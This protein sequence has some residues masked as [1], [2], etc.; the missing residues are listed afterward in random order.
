M[1]QD[2]GITDESKVS[3]DTDDKP[4]NYDSEM[5]SEPSAKSGSEGEPG[6]ADAEP[7]KAEKDNSTLYFLIAAAIIIILTIVFFS[8]RFFAAEK[9]YPKVTYNGFVFE[10]YAGLWNTQWQQD[11]QLYNLRL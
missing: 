4:A 2:D 9:G 10:Y 11:G 5:K 8:A 1:G 7:G 6:K 3:K